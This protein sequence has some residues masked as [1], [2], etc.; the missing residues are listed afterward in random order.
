MVWRKKFSFDEVFEIAK[1]RVKKKN[2]EKKLISYYKNYL[3][4]KGLSVKRKYSIEWEQ[5]NKRVIIQ[6]GVGK[7]KHLSF[8]EDDKAICLN[9][10][11]RS[12]ECRDFL[13]RKAS[14]RM[15]R[16]KIRKKKPL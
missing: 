5:K 4:K 13:C 14:N 11:K 15:L 1:E 10:K 3:N 7:C 9:Y 8:I 6:V 12:E 2:I 16:N